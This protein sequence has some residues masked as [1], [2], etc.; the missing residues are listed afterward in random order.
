[1]RDFTS[2]VSIL[3]LQSVTSQVPM[4]HIYS[5]GVDRSGCPFSHLN[6]SVN[7]PAIATPSVKISSKCILHV[8]VLNPHDMN[9][10]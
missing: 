6:N 2:F 1:M 7:K 8:S 9:Y 10:L 3:S 4:R 5:A